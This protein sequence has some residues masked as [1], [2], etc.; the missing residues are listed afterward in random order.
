MKKVLFGIFAHP[1]DEAFGPGGTL[2]LETDA[3]TELH[4]ITL[5]AG[6]AGCNPDCQEDLALC[7]LEE[8][9]TAANIL[10]ATSTTCL[11]Y[12][13]SQLAN[14]ALVEIVQKITDIVAKTIAQSE[15]CTVEFMSFEFGGITGHIDHIVASRAAAQVFYAYKTSDTRFHRLRLFCLPRSWQPEPDLGWL[16]MDCGVDDGLVD[17]VIDTSRVHDRHVQ[18][19]RAH[20]SQRADAEHILRRFG[21]PEKQ[22]DHFIVRT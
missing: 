7:R 15:D 11:G 16:F 8:W 3:G 9:K 4:L 2:I 6:D 13:D 22:H 5:T 17:E 12:K 21:E 19:I 18:A 10:G 20:A 14:H 1:D